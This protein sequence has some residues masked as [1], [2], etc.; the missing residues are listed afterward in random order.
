MDAVGDALAPEIDDAG[1]G[2]AQ[3]QRA[4]V[5]GQHAVDLFGHAAVKRTQARLEMR[6]R[7]FQLCC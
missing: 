3:Q 6:D 7:N 1:F 4:E 2:R 5:I